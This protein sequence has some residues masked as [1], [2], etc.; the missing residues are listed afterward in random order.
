MFVKN[1]SVSTKLL[2]ILIL[3][4]LGVV[5]F[6]AMRVIDSMAQA[7]AA[8]QI[9]QDAAFVR[10]VGLLIHELQKERGAT[11]SFISSHGAKMGDRLPGL[12]AASDMAVQTFKTRMDSW[13]SD[14]KNGMQHVLAGLEH[15][16]EVRRKAD[17]FAISAADARAQYT[18]PIQALLE[19]S[20]GLGR[21]STDVES[22]R[23]TDSYVCYMNMKERAGRERAMLAGLISTGKADAAQLLK[24]SENIGEYQLALAQFALNTRPD[25]LAFHREKVAGRAVDEVERMRAA[26]LE[27]PIGQELG[28]D[29]VSWFDMATE[30]INL[31]KTVEDKLAGDLQA[32]AVAKQDTAT[33]TLI[34]TAMVTA[35]LLLV[36]ILTAW[37]SAQS[38]TRP[39]RQMRTAIGEV[40][41]NGDF[42]QRI[43]VSGHD[44]VGQTALSFNELM[45]TMQ[46][47]LHNIL[48]SVDKVF[49]AARTLSSTSSHVA[50]NSAQL[51]DATY[52]MAAK[53]QQ[54]TFGIDQVSVSAREAL[55]IS[56]KSGDLSSHGGTIIHKAAS[57]MTQIADTVRETSDTIEALGQQSNRISSV[58]QVIKDVAD[59]T[60]LL[61]LNAAIEAARAGEQGRGFAVVADEVRKLA[62]RTSQATG[63]I[64]QMISAIQ[65]SA[66]TA[67]NSMATV[68]AKVGG[69][70]A[71]AQQ[72][73]DAIN[74]INDGA[75]QVISVVNN[76][77]A[78]L[79]EQS[80]AG[81]DITTQVEEV[82]HMTDVN[83]A[84]NDTA[85]AA[86]HLEQLANDMRAT[87]SKF[88][89]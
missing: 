72:A 14:G 58:V 52:T 5:W 33:A 26:V 88:R 57:E 77:S 46:A 44:E 63:E 85:G 81:T 53:V 73:G 30:R 22:M 65:G 19:L 17:G 84:A 71:L 10:V 39:L 69:G 41:K 82:V 12:R 24:A 20:G 36:A 49:D 1:M 31:M 28:L 4:M 89:I 42:T 61:A 80:G 64:T 67:V 62:E 40:E 60:N 11:S 54:V 66:R 15:L 3:P 7:S 43:P 55:E 9:V 47:T 78:A 29:S 56:R 6:G 8:K 25:H 50:A 68:V 70:V 13:R 75:G 16:G 74:Q 45:S 35:I 18:G 48:G 27:T 2:V 79:A 83:G 32:R 37:L 51:A 21:G 34:S 23:D 76:I 59:Q 87:V 86:S 38:I